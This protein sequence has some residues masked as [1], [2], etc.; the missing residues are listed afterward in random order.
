ML[1]LVSMVFAGCSLTLGGPIVAGPSQ[2]SLRQITLSPPVPLVARK[3]PRPVY[4]VLNPAKVPSEMPV[5]VNGA[6]QGGQMRDTQLFV[7]R[8][9]QRAFANYFD[10]V[11][12]VTPAQVP[13]FGAAVIVDVRLDRLATVSQ[14]IEDQSSVEVRG[15]A[16]LN[17]SIALRPANASDYLWSFTGSSQGDLT[18]DPQ[19]AYRS[20]FEH[21]IADMLKDYAQQHVQERLQGR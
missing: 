2:M 7:E 1:A 12:V 18:S 3:S 20:L 13:T 8:D 10:Q 14:T 6:S 16:S 19:V 9:L 17:W 5:F 21:A 11:S 4:L 15:R